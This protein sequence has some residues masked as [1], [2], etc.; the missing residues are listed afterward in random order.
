MLELYVSICVQNYK[1]TLRIIYT[2][3]KQTH[4]NTQ[5]LT[6]DSDY[7]LK[8]NTHTRIT[9]DKLHSLS[10][11]FYH[12]CSVLIIFTDYFTFANFTCNQM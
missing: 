12:S 3:H 9:N 7:V 8:K 2:K 10:L 5:F 11:L 4:T 6:A 1:R